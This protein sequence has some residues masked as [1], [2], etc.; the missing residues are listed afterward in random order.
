MLYIFTV[1]LVERNYMPQG[2]HLVDP[3]AV[4][5]SSKQDLV[6]LAREIQKV[7]IC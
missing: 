3:N 2:I 1:A 4:A 7:Y 6:A 5:K